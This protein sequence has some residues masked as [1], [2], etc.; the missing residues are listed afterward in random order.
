MTPAPQL[1]STPLN[2]S[3]GASSVATSSSKSPLVKQVDRLERS[4]YQRI[5]VTPERT[6]ANRY[7]DPV[8]GG[9]TNGSSSSRSQSSQP[10]RHST[11]QVRAMTKKVAKIHKSPRGFSGGATDNSSTDNSKSTPQSSAEFIRL[12]PM[13]NFSLASSNSIRKPPQASAAGI[14]QPAGWKMG[15]QP[16]TVSR[17]PTQVGDSTPVAADISTERPHIAA[18]GPPLPPAANSG[19]HKSGTGKRSTPRRATS[20]SLEPQ[21]P[22]RGAFAGPGPGPHDEPTRK[23]Q[24]ITPP[25][26][27]MYTNSY[28]NPITFCVGTFTNPSRASRD[29]S[30]PEPSNPYTRRRY[31]ELVASQIDESPDDLLAVEAAGQLMELQRRDYDKDFAQ[32]TKEA[33]S[34]LKRRRSN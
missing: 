8:R 10:S 31:D 27:R 34:A 7:F 23:K 6:A 18:R 9:Y 17:Y 2:F 13:G 16:G 11:G 26:P 24:K 1:T 3:P 22:A 20:S 15:M 33:N 25:G 32:R 14:R 5:S 29:S 30:I 28:M 19:G 4:K 12:P 21:P